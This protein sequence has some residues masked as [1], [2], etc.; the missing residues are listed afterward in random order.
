MA[1]ATSEKPKKEKAAPAVKTT[2]KTKTAAKTKSAKA[3]AAAPAEAEAVHEQ[4]SAVLRPLLTLRRQVDE[5]VEDAFGRLQHIRLP[6]IE[7][8]T[9]TKSGEEEVGVARFDFS[10][11]D[12]AVTVTAEMPGMSEDD[13]EVLVENGVLTIK[14]EKKSEREEKGEN[15]YLSERRFGSFSRAFRLPE[16]IV[17]DEIGADFKKGVLTVTMPKTAGSKQAPKR[18]VVKSS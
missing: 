1:K 4:E 9:F 17:A 8:P 14:G 11:N 6:R 16:G 7:W 12:K 3:G 13:I 18:I 10:E 15:Y 2:V 5:L